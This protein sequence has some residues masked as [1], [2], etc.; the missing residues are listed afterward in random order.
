MQRSYISFLSRQQKPLFERNQ[1]QS[2][3]ENT[4]S[5]GPGNN[6]LE[7][8]FAGPGPGKGRILGAGTQHLFA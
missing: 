2:I 3:E 4:W 5:Q 6:R 7:A 1:T 8:S